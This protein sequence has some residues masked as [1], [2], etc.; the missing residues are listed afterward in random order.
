M[1]PTTPKRPF[2]EVE[3][4]NS[5][6]AFKRFRDNLSPEEDLNSKEAFRL[7]WNEAGAELVKKYLDH[8]DSFSEELLQDTV[9]TKENFRLRWADFLAGDMPLEGF[10]RRLWVDKQRLKDQAVRLAFLRN[11]PGYSTNEAIT[12][13]QMSEALKCRGNGAE[14]YLKSLLNK[15]AREALA[16]GISVEII[17][18]GYDDSDGQPPRSALASSMTP[19]T[20]ADLTNYYE[21]FLI[22]IFEVVTE[23]FSKHKGTPNE[24]L[25]KQ[26]FDYNCPKNL[27]PE[28]VTDF[29][30]AVSKKI[31]HH[32]GS[33]Q[34]N[35]NNKASTLL[36]K[37]AADMFTQTEGIHPSFNVL[38][39]IDEARAL[40]LS[41]KKI[42]NEFSFFR[43][44]R[45]ALQHIPPNK[46]FFTIL[47]DTTLQVANF[48]PAPKY[49]PSARGGLEKGV[50]LFDPIYQIS[51]LDV[52]VPTNS[53]TSWNELTS[54]A[55]LVNYGTPVYGAYWRDAQAKSIN[56]SEVF[57]HIISLAQSKLL[58]SNQLPLPQNLTKYQ[59]LALLGTTIQP[60]LSGTLHLNSEL[61][62][63]HAAHCDYISPGRDLILANYP[64]QF[65]LASAANRTLA[66]KEMLICCIKKLTA[67]L[68]LGLDARGVAGELASRIILSCAMRKAMRNSKEDP[69]EIPYG[70]SVRL[71]DFL[72]ALTGR[73][74]DEGL[75][76]VDYK[77]NVSPD[78]PANEL[79]ARVSKRLAACCERNGGLYIKLGQAI[80]IQA[81][82]L[83][84]VY[85]HA[86]ARIFDAA[87]PMPFHLV[88]QVCSHE[89]P[90]GIDHPL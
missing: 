49:D 82:L 88:R 42:P 43:N 70:C 18:K 3:P 17:K 41:P 76:I 54:A 48:N 71:A 59:A 68:R 53:P 25:L 16:S 8:L 9:L 11:H 28:E 81:A 23:F 87:S 27:Q 6:Q 83:P 35:P 14:L 4:L 63:S 7:F 33:F 29:S 2:A 73:S 77:L 57:S 15:P 89:L 31:D 45:R 1:E 90:G 30:K 46:G 69:V 60:R 13:P 61:V 52:L 56:Q 37:A 26:W 22:A 66:D 62:S 10:C 20:V 32:Y 21:S 80:T 44:F 65:I 34:K 67:T 47:A 79:H 64:S 19:D 12:V 24:E 72:N 75:T 84:P 86:L 51:S 39:A 74:E 50:R 38:L 78:R 55:R 36:K 5:D 58:C 40:L 85:S